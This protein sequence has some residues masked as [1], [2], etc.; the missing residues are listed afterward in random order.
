MNVGPDADALTRSPNAMDEVTEVEAS[1]LVK[2]YQ[3]GEAAA[4]ELLH[5]RLGRAM[6]RPLRRY[7]PAQL[8]STVTRQDLTQQ[9]WVILAELARR[10]HPTGSFLAYFFRS[11]PREVERFVQRS[12]PGRRTKQT[13]VI[14]VPHDELLGAA[15]KIAAGD[16]F[17]DRALAWT[18][19]I[20]SLPPQQQAALTLRTIEGRTFD[21]I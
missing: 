10:W 4:L 19:E 15:D 2:R 3:Q 7:H 6:A 12:H 14:A 17:A 13:Q 9:S 20:A 5:A 16:P 21:S 8:P 18:D 11:F 1:D